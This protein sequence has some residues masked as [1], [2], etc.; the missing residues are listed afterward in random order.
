VISA[1]GLNAP[2]ASPLLTHHGTLFRKTDERQ[3][4]PVAP[5]QGDLTVL[6]RALI[7]TAVQLFFEKPA[8]FTATANY[9][10][11]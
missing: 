7:A 1:V 4:A 5:Q 9:S 3:G 2:F 10:F 6:Q 8:N 11:A